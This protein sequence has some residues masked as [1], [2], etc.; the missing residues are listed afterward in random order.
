[1]LIR[2]ANTRDAEDILALHKRSVAALCSAS[3]SQEHISWWFHERTSSIYSPAISSGA[4]W[5]AEVGGSLVGFV[6]ATEGEVT[7]L[8]VSPEHT[9]QGYA[10]QMLEHAL[11]VAGS[12]RREVGVE[13]TL[14]SVSFYRQ[15]G[16]KEVGE[17]AFER[18][19]GSLKYPTVSMRLGPTPTDA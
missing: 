17:Q 12:P 18:G 19:P 5:V 15:H 2:L 3:Y 7:L 6:G 1:M 4:L 10:S 16:F 11:A 8:F 13:A 9:G 14:N